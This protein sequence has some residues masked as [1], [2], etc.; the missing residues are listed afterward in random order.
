VQPYQAFDPEAARGIRNV[1]TQLSDQDFAAMVQLEGLP[2]STSR[3]G[4]VQKS[5]E[6]VLVG[7]AGTSHVILQSKHQLTM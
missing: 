4:F 6:D 2:K 5:V 3:R 7:R 1:E